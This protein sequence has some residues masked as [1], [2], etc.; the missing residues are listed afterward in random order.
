MYQEG[1]MSRATRAMVAA[2]AALT[3]VACVDQP[4]SAP[5]PV[6]APA[7]PAPSTREWAAQ[8]CR[9]LDPVYG[10]LGTPPPVDLADGAA[11]LQAYQ[12]HLAEVESAT[13]QA[14]GRVGTLGTPPVENGE[15][16]VADI[17]E[18]LA[19]VGRDAA[20]TRA[21]LD[22]VDPT[23]PL[24]VEQATATAVNGLG[25]LGNSPQLL[26]L[27]GV[28]PQLDEAVAEA[29]ECNDPLLGTQPSSSTGS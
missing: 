14:S 22:Q 27:L 5:P 6:A 7:E 16:A 18:H 1:I 20:R 17:R 25:T 8:L 26:D 12:V 29:P 24:A 2:A 11:T 9:T 21:L 13:Q 4:G 3:L 10:T 23:D 28:Y 15:Q 19:D